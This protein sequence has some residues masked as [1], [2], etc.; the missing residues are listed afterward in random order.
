[1]L[2]LWVFGGVFTMLGALCYAELAGMFPGAGGQY[3]YLG[4]AFGRFW[5]FLYG[6]TLF[7]VI[8]TGFNAA[9]GIAFAR[10][11]GVLVPALAEENV[12]L[13]VPLPGWHWLCQSANGWP[14]LH[15]CLSG[16]GG[17]WRINSA[18]LVACGVI[19]LLT[20]I[21]TRG[22]HRGAAV[23]NVFT[24][25]K[26]AA[27]GA[28]IVA[29]LARAGDNLGHFLPLLPA[30]Q[31][32]L[33]TGFAAG[34][35]VALSKALFAYDGWSTG[36]FVAEETRQPQTTVPR[37]LLLGTGGVTLVYL[38]TNVAYL[39][40]VPI[41]Q[42][43]RATEDRVA[44]LVAVTLFGRVG[45]TLVVAAIL[46]S[47]FGC[48]NGLILGGARVSY[49]MA[50]HG[51]FFRRCGRLHERTH[52]PAGALVYQGVWSCVLTASGSYSAL[53]TYTTF[54]SVLFGA[55]TVVGVVRLRR[56]RPGLPRP[57]RCW[58]YPVTPAVYLL[59]AVPFL[60]YVIQGDPQST[61]IGLALVASGV[62]A[63]FV[64]SRK[65]EVQ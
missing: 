25:L 36:T 57:V 33:G 41:D 62:P 65:K 52:A 3:V 8:Q 23:Q 28:L 61:L 10:Y 38:L 35:A 31:T 24:I 34:L 2:L 45:S 63:Y 51:L 56:T 40:A 15:Q 29:G 32:V 47:T 4:E 60:V 37:A 48:L 42:I 39:A 6:W 58:G 11:L 46:V 27:L 19:G 54:A 50:R 17:Q 14:A 16:M 22:V 7:A 44:A 9:V 21:N 43:A 55:L 59:I 26:F 18:Q 53:L 12:L 49:A 13:R 1:L 5:A 64:W 30:R 20:A